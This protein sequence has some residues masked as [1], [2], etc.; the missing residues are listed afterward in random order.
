MFDHSSPRTPPTERGSY[1]QLPLLPESVAPAASDR[2]ASVVY[3]G[4]SVAGASRGHALE[5][6]RH[7]PDEPKAPELRWRGRTQRRVVQ[8][9][10][11]ALV[12]PSAVDHPPLERVA[13]YG[14]EEAKR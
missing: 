5:A 9:D 4:H 8:P 11:Y 1:E 14:N 3:S 13:W 2:D 10:G 6:A 7:I 12:P